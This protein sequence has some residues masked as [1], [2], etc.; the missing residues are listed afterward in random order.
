MHTSLKKGNTLKMYD[1][2]CES[3]KNP[4]CGDG[5]KGDEE[6]ALKDSTG[7]RKRKKRMTRRRRGGRR[8]RG[9]RERRQRR[10]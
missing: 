10:R 1:L 5:D 3:L 6:G 2:L 7:T 9:R 8:R 4:L